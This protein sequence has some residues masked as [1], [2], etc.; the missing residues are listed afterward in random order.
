M[1][2]LI[3]HVLEGLEPGLDGLALVE[4]L[5]E[6]LDPE[7][8]RSAA[9]LVRLRRRAAGKLRFAGALDLTARGLEQASHR[10]VAGYRAE[11]FAAALA[12]DGHVLDATAGIGSDATALLAAG[13]RSL[14]AAERD[15][16]LA[17][18]LAHNLG[19]A[20]RELGLAAPPPVL[21]QDAARPAL[22]A[23]LVL[24]DPDRRVDGKRSGDPAR[25]SPPWDAV[26]PLLARSRGGCVKL[27][28]ATEV[29][30]L[31]LP[32]GLP[33]HFEWISLGGELKEVA[34]WTGELSGSDA[35]TRIAT[36]L[37]EREGGPHAAS[38]RGTAVR[39]A[40]LDPAEASGV[41]WIHDPDPSL[42]R[43]GLLGLAARR[44]GLA[45]LD[46]HIAYLGGASPADTPLLRPHRV[47]ASSRLDRRAVRAMLREHDI[48][49]L[50]VKKR[51]HPDDAATLARRLRGPGK[52]R[53]TLLVTRIADR[54]LAFLVE[55]APA[56]RTLP[57]PSSI[58]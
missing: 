45:P 14:V 54:H 49:P 6:R 10:A 25:W 41:A 36:A 9:E 39:V 13:A 30:R 16:V 21:L 11:R 53:G 47:L 48:G 37:R 24:V 17:R 19:V 55:P 31:D 5:R 52:R 57:P 29:A 4:R 12:P 32:P 1:N 51:G 50:T 7:L 56:E 20:A 42:L 40:A 28:A 26:L 3:Q 27:A 38:L 43:S 23:D 2:P 44:H 58:S 46:P 15:P 18:T 35:G 33:H 22:R 34:L 8:A